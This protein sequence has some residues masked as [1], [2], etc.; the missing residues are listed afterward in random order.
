MVDAWKWQLKQVLYCYC[1]I[2]NARY[3]LW[4]NCHCL[5]HSLLLFSLSTICT[6]IEVVGVGQ[7]PKWFKKKHFSFLLFRRLIDIH[8]QAPIVFKTFKTGLH[9]LHGSI[10]VKPNEP[11]I[12]VTVNTCQKYALRLAS[13]GHFSAQR[14]ITI[15][16]KQST[17][18]KDFLRGLH[19]YEI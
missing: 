18:K 11:T 17:M 14:F 13:I 6:P 7:P 19:R 9:S 2:S 4:L 1:F 12:T 10:K 15:R 16:I 5:M 3:L 8:W